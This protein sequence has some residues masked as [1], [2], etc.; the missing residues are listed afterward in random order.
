MR[1]KAPQCD[2]LNETRIASSENAPE[3]KDIA[4]PKYFLSSDDAEQAANLGADAVTVSN[5]G[6]G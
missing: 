1:C 6:G 4:S 5:H 2:N 3:R